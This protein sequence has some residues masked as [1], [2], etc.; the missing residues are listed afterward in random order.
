VVRFE[1]CEGWDK[2][3]TTRRDWG[4]LGRQAVGLEEASGESHHRF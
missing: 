3:G 4:M 1:V 2:G